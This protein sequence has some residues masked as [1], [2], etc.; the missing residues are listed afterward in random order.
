[1]SSDHAKGKIEGRGGVP[2]GGRKMCK[3]AERRV[4]RGGK[5]LMED[6]AIIAHLPAR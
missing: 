5:M 4:G 2:G 6:G 3:K 1:M